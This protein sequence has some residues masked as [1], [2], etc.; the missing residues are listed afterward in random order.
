M[1]CICDTLTGV[2][3][4]TSYRLDP[5]LKER[6]A[7]R[8]ETEGITE[9]ALVTRL[10]EQG[11][12]AIEHPGIVFRP[13][14]SGWRAGLSGGPDVDEVV[15]SI[16]STGATGDAAVS[17][18]ADALGIDPRLVRVAVDYAAEHLEEIESRLQANE[19]AVARVEKL[20]AARASVLS[21]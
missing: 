18:A 4:S 11:L 2:A 5:G 17:S 14:P 13:G 7:R 10:L 3:T 20:A 19:A 21:G 6:L 16:R 1:S 15:R 9:T 12:A 8:A